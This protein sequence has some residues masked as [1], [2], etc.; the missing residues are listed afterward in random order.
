[1]AVVGA[2]Y[3]AVEL[4]GIFNTLG[5][6]THLIIR[7]DRVLRTFDPIIQDTLTE[8]LV[9]SGIKLHTNA[10]IVKVTSTGSTDLSL[11]SPK[12]AHLNN[13]QSI[14]VDT[15]L[16]A[17]G[18][19]GN[20]KGLGLEQ[21]GVKLDKK[22]NIV[23]DDYQ[24]TTVPSIVAIGDVQGKALL[25]P[26]AIAAG[27]KLSNRLFG[28]KEGDKLDYNNIPSV[29]FS[30]PPI[31]TT[32]LTEP[33]ARAKFGDDKV[34]IYQSKFVSLS[35]TFLPPEEKFTTAMKLV[36]VG[37]EEKVVGLHIIGEGCDEITQ[38]FGV[39]IKMGARKRDLDDC[40]AIH[41]TSGEELV[42]MK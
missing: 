24:N 30:E 6:E 22:G 19:S 7:K 5:T 38:G 8:K 2:G 1:V 29:V 17:V 37:E 20:T 9:K 3:I 12:I 32:G 23:V 27:R 18:R 34:K 33:E 16:L 26:V 4:A 28:G 25:T 11:P 41:P 39:A 35:N 10:Q 40:V 36:C 14:E 31:G 15:V 21:V 13:G 42:T